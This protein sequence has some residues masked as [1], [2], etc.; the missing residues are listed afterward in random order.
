MIAAAFAD[1]GPAGEDDEPWETEEGYWDE[2]GD[3]YGWEQQDEA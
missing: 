1:A 2:R 3:W